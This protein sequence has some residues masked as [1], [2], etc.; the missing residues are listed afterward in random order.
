MMCPQ[1]RSD[2]LDN[3]WKQVNSSHSNL[4]QLKEAFCFLDRDGD[5]QM[6]PFDLNIF[7]NSCSGITINDEEIRA[8]IACADTDGNGRVDYDEFQHLLGAESEESRSTLAS[9]D[10]VEHASLQEVFR[11]LDQDG[12]GVLSKYDLE[13]F[14]TKSGHLRSQEELEMM[15]EVASTAQNHSVSFEDFVEYFLT[16]S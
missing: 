2:V 12:D 9:S 15:L 11:I 8:M 13:Q 4:H 7:F 16:A 3:L 6:S 10:L 14:A 1:S 5:G